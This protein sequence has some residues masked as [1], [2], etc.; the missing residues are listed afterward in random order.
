MSALC[1]LIS[2]MMTVN[3]YLFMGKRQWLLT[4]F[5]LRTKLGLWTV[6]DTG[7][8]VAGLCFTGVINQTHDSHLPTEAAPTPASPRQAGWAGPRCTR[9]RGCSRVQAQTV[10]AQGLH[11]AHPCFQ[12]AKTKEGVCMQVDFPRY[13]CH[14]LT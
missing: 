1:T 8:N 10:P 3:L 11:C 14:F 12:F 6:V 13:G 2:P 5:P 9:A 7:S 4:P